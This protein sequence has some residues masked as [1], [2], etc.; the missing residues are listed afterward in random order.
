MN[1]FQSYKNLGRDFQRTYLHF[2]FKKK[3]CLELEGMEK[4]VFYIY[5]YGFL[6]ALD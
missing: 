3:P 6:N 4:S 1:Q 2:F 5:I